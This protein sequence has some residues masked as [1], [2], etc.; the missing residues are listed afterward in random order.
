M[1]KTTRDL[2][3]MKRVPGTTARYA[4][5]FPNGAEDDVTLY[6]ADGARLVRVFR[7][8][9]GWSPV[10]EPRPKAAVWPTLTAVA[11]DLGVRKR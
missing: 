4:S 8:G 6:A 5:T 1:T 10:V 7:V 9:E 3:A 11:L 2:R